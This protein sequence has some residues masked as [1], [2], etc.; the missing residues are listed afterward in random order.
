MVNPG[1]SYQH[2]AQQKHPIITRDIAKIVLRVR[3]YFEEEKKG[4]KISANKV[5]ER[6][7]AA[8]KISKNIISKIKTSDDI[9]SFPNDST[10]I[11]ERK[12]KVPEIFISI[13]R[14][15]ITEIV[16]KEKTSPKIVKI[17]IKLS[18]QEYE[19][20]LFQERPEWN[21]SMETMRR[22]MNNN[23]FC[24]KNRKTHYEFS[25]E[26]EDIMLMRDNYLEWIEKY[27][28]EGYIIYYQDETWVF[29][30]MSPS[31]SWKYLSHREKSTEDLKVPPGPGDRSIVSHIGSAEYGLLHN[32]L[33]LFT[34]RKKSDTDYHSEMNQE[35]FLKWMND[36]V[37]PTI[38]NTKKKSVV[39]LDRARYHTM[40]TE[41]T[42]PP[43]MSWKKTKMI[44]MIQ[45]W[46]NVPEDWPIL[47]Y[48]VKTKIQL[49]NLLK[50]LAP[51]KKYL[52]QELADKFSSRQFHIK[53]IFL[54]VAHPELN[55]IEMIWGTVKRA[56]SSAN[57][58][59]KLSQVK[60]L[61]RHELA[62]Y[63]ASTF[64][65]FVQHVINVENNF[66]H[67]GT[68]LDDYF[69]ESDGD[70]YSPDTEESE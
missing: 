70:S 62:R 30:N 10:I 42:K 8:T 2:F 49:F 15:I 25:R 22:F 35:V 46:G 13:I 41:F 31:K 9:L 59:F 11:R 3:N 32:C 17:Y 55:P 47:W 48:K 69:V 37:F 23:G 38:Q 29:K 51:P 61:T 20:V 4:N 68:I 65:R 24:Y 45:K 19:Y 66:R 36:T 43:L 52:V 26:R 57:S 18:T 56:V 12:S 34:G 54:P 50:K 44:E 16:I 63:N 27:R 39:V 5:V 33:L 58:N 64:K 14:K 7:I 1:S 21:W 67:Y 53:I 60:E 40:L 6:T 28:N